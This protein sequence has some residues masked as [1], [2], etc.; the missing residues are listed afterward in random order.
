M[1]HLL[2]NTTTHLKIISIPI[3]PLVQI[4]VKVIDLP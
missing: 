3:E 4:K 1:K 2:S